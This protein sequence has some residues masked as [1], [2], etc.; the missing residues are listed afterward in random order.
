MERRKGETFEELVGGR[1]REEDFVKKVAEGY[2]QGIFEKYS[3]GVKG[4]EAV[5]REVLSKVRGNKEGT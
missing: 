4:L 3:V 5:E 2:Q 1:W